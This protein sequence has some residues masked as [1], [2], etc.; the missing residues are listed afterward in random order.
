MKREY[1]YVLLYLAAVVAANLIIARF[2]P[3]AA[4]PVAFALIGLDLTARDGLHDAWKNRGLG[5]KMAALIAAGSLLSWAIN[6]QAGPIAL[7]SFVA[8]AA[9][10]AAD[11]LIYH[12][13]GGKSR[14]LRINGSNLV[15]AAVDSLIFPILAFGWPPLWGIVVGQ[16]LAKT[17]GG[18]IWSLLLGRRWAYLANGVLLLDIPLVA[19][20]FRVDWEDDS[21]VLGFYANRTNET[22]D[23]FL[24]AEN[25]G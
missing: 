6:R 21:L 10:G 3:A 11:A 1:F 5:W 7:A 23:E 20:I 19:I 12:L 14:L 2:G 25:E 18:F 9:T 24:A 13:L 15:S 16:F 22:L 8:F 17:L 4:I